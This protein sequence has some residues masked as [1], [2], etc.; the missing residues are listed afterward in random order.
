[1]HQYNI[2]APFER[3]AVDVVGSFPQRDQGNRYLVI[4]MEYF[5]KWPDA[6]AVPNQE[7][8]LVVVIAL[9]TIFFCH[10]G[11]PRGLQNDQGRNFKSCLMQVL[12]CLGVGKT[13][14]TPLHLRQDSM[15]KRYIKT[16]EEHLPSTIT[17][18]T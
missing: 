13:R 8:S 15:A 16:V 10:F 9:V 14:T 3:I 4:A 6:Y 7:A 2:D 12:Q 1:M 17:P 11:V 18:T 5:K